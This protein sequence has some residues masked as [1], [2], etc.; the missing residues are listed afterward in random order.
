MQ[1]SLLQSFFSQ[2]YD[3]LYFYIILLN[4]QYLHTHS[5]I[6]NSERIELLLNFIYKFLGTLKGNGAGFTKLVERLIRGAWTPTAMETMQ[7]SL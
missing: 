2:S 5:E 7:P 6:F 4:R 1:S 3:Y